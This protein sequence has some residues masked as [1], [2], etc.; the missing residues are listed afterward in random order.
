MVN[1][2]TMKTS[3]VNN[4]MLEKSNIVG[5]YPVPIIYD[6]DSGYHPNE[7]EIDYL[8]SCATRKPGMNQISN[9]SHVL[10]HESMKNMKSFLQKYLDRYSKEIMNIEQNFYITQTWFTRNQ[11][12]ESH[13]RHEHHNSI[14]SG[15]FYVNADK[16]MGKITFHNTSN[17]IEKYFPFTYNYFDYNLFNSKNWWF[18]VKT[19][20]IIVFPSW[21]EHS[22]SE[23]QTNETRLC[24]GFNSFV[25]GKIGSQEHYDDIILK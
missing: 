6:Y 5:L 4:T 11:P 20:T 7:D 18:E 3:Q 25:R 2:W 19:G 16:N 17:S 15:V 14:I 24:V 22:V 1:L 8:F 9:S 23:N 10:E 12:G 13:G 21:L